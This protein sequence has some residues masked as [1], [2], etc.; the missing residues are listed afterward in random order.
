MTTVVPPRSAIP[1]QYTWN[2]PSVFESPEAW[3][4]ALEDLQ[5]DL[6]RIKAY[7]GRLKESPAVLAE[8]FAT[9][10]ELHKRL[11]I[12]YM[13]AYMTYSVDTTNQAAAAMVGQAQAIYGQVL[14]ASAFF[15]PELIAIGEPTVREWVA[16]EPQL[17]YTAHYVDNLF[18]QQAHVRSA[19]VEELLGMVADPFGGTGNTYNMLT[20]SDLKF[21]PATGN[22][23]ATHDL[24]QST[25]DRLLNHP[26]REVRRTAWEQYADAYLAHKNTLASSL[27]T[28]VKQ[29]VFQARARRYNSTLEMALF[30]HN[31]PRSVYDNLLAIFQKNLPTWHRY[32]RIRRQALG[33]DTLHP[34][35]I[36]APLTSAQPEITYEQAVEWICAGLAPMGEEYVARVR[37]GC[38]QDR[39]VDVFPNQGKSAGAF[40]YGSHGT[41]PFIMMS[42][43]NTINSLSTLAHELGHSMHSYLTWQ[44]QPVLYSD[45]SMFVA[46]VA[47]NFHQA[48]V[49]AY[50]L[51]TNSDPD[52][53]I[54]VIEEAMDNFHRYFFIMPTLARFELAMHER[55]ERGEGLSAD[56][57]IALMTDLFSEG[58]GGEMHI[59]HERVGITWAQFGHL[60]VDYYVFQYATGIS[61]ANAIAR[62]ILSG[63]PGAAADHI[64]FLSA[65]GAMYP[66]DA[67]KLAGIDLSQPEPVE[68]AF[69][70]LA[71]LVDR[72]EQ[73]TAR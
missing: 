3:Q 58:Y 45:Y 66:V 36:W 57:L 55:I 68:A 13:Y 71:G 72:L 38:L 28:S 16:A 61:G 10:E 40:S 52:F 22:D 60:Y 42:F 59:D 26:D 29:N 25:I 53:Q 20:D 39:W 34:Y 23:G 32:W 6:P 19:E 33:V 62:R 37:Q 69:E 46:E 51:D 70:V 49:R 1:E 11:G 9:L 43:N 24:T 5:A 35:D 54:N 30:Q 8:A 73:L 56:D 21:P 63:E 4:A 17:A 41:H 7:E 27:V 44:N 50:L 18:R 48:M 47:S 67:L 64:R 12:V 15:D 65:G 14:A 31:I 2:A